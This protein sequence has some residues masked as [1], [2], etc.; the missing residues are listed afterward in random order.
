[1]DRKQTILRYQKLLKVKALSKL[2]ILK[3]I[4]KQYSLSSVGTVDECHRVAVC[5]LFLY[6]QLG[7]SGRVESCRSS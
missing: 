1:M 7:A 2:N 4:K 5:C 6:C 3:V